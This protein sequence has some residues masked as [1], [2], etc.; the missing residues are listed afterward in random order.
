M[1]TFSHDLQSSIN[2]GA[3]GHAVAAAAAAVA[4]NLI[5]PLPTSAETVST[6]ETEVLS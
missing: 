4:V 3:S 2:G 1:L 6:T 5:P